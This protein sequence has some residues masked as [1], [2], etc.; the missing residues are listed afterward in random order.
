MGEQLFEHVRF[1][2]MGAH[3]D[4]HRGHH[5]RASKRR[6]F[7][8]GTGTQPLRQR[9]GILRAPINAPTIAQGYTAQ[10]RAAYRHKPPHS[11]GMP[12]TP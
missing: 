9:V 1:R 10:S 8:L 7:L 11:A 4:G 6:V 2:A 5:A 3:A 12:I